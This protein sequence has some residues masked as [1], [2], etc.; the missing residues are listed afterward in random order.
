MAIKKSTA[1]VVKEPAETKQL[2]KY[3]VEARELKIATPE[4]VKNATTFLS[5]L[6]KFNDKITSEKEKVTKPLNQALKA[7]RERWKPLE[8]KLEVAIALV[9]RGLTDYQTKAVAAQRVAEKKIVDRV[10]EGKGKITP[11]T[12]I[13]KLDEVATPDQTVA[14]EA[15]AVQFR[16][17]KKFEVMDLTMLPIEYH[18]A[19]ETKIREAMKQGNE[20]P[21]VRYYEEQVP[22]NTR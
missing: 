6:N 22:Y 17:V 14:T 18:L 11:E 9:R 8:T 1:L 19:D 5:T 16:A 21:G 2:D 3:L 7:E 15:G 10:G 12:A 13:R 20:L 4:D